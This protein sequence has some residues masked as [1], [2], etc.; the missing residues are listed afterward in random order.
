MSTARST[1]LTA[2]A[3]S[4]STSAA[5]AL[6]AL[7]QQWLLQ[8]ITSITLA[9]LCFTAGTGELTADAL[10]SAMASVRPSAMRQLS[11]EIPNVKWEDVGGQ[12]YGHPACLLL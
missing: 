1:A 8:L 3:G 7:L 5:V 4:E 10:E 11:L 2:L 12:V 9:H 6:K